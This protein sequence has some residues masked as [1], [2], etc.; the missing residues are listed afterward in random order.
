MI[1]PMLTTCR[2]TD[3]VVSTESH[4]SSVAD[5]ELVHCD[6]QEMPTLEHCSSVPQVSPLSQSP[7]VSELFPSSSTAFPPLLVSDAV[8][9]PPHSEPLALAAM[10]EI[11][12]AELSSSAGPTAST[13]PTNQH[14]TQMDEPADQ[15]QSVA[16][17]V[18]L[19]QLDDVTM[20]FLD[21]MRTVIE[22]RQKLIPGEN[23]VQHDERENHV[24][25]LTHSWV[26][27][28]DLT[29][30]ERDHGIM[31]VNQWASYFGIS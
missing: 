30:E 15:E 2:H 14:L 20:L 29:K 28:E 24:S 3:S 5:R 13:S 26:N 25:V 16:Q 6:S 18:A 7:V 11:V 17:S 9:P 12:G 10:G 23:R 27:W 1:D 21:H 19:K 22:C 4:H 31:H 8:S